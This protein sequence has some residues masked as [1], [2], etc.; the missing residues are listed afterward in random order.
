MKVYRDT[1]TGEIVTEEQLRAEF[2]ELKREQPEEY[3]Y[4]FADYIRNITDKNGTMEEVQ[5]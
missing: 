5:K 4:T 2:D 3:N 1:E